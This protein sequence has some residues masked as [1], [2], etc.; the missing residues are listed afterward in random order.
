MD[1]NRKLMG[2]IVIMVAFSV[3]FS[4]GTY[5]WGHDDGAMKGFCF[6]KEGSQDYP[7]CELGVGDNYCQMNISPKINCNKYHTY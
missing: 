1:E 3:G 2:L 6:G 4:I 7:R 5:F